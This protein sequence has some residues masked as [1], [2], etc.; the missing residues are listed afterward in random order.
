M[1]LNTYLALNKSKKKTVLCFNT[2][3]QLKICLVT[4]RIKIKQGIFDDKLSYFFK[5]LFK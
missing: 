3:K 4:T 5:V 2:I 1:A